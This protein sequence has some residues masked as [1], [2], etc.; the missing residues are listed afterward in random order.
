MITRYDMRRAPKEPNEAYSVSWIRLRFDI[1]KQESHAIVGKLRD[2]AVNF[3][4]YK[5]II[6]YNQL[7]RLILQ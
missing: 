5:H 1:I 2:A 4:R 6:V 7:F 3:D